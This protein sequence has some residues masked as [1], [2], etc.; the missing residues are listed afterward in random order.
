MDSFNFHFER[1]SN[2]DLHPLSCPVS[3]LS[4]AKSTSSIDQFTHHHGKGDSA[5]SSFSGGSNAPD[6]SSPFIPYCREE[7]NPHSLQYTDMK[8]VK[9]VYHPNELNSNPKSVEK[10]YRSMEAISQQCDQRSSVVGGRCYDQESP[11]PPPPPFMPPPPP[12]APPPPPPPTR[13]DSFITIRNLENSRSYP[14]PEGQV[15]EKTHRRSPADSPDAACPRPDLDYGRRVSQPGLRDPVSRDGADQVPEPQKPASVSRSPPAFLPQESLE[16]QPAGSADPTETQRPRRHSAQEG[17]FSAEKP[18]AWTPTVLNGNIQ[19]KGQFYFVTGVCKPPDPGF[20]GTLGGV[21]EGEEERRSEG[22]RR[23]PVERTHSKV[24]ELLRIIRHRRQGSQDPQGERAAYLRNQALSARN[25]H[26]EIHGG[27]NPRGPSPVSDQG[28]DGFDGLDEQGQ[29]MQGRELGLSSRRH[30]SSSHHIFY[31][32]PEDRLSQ[33]N[34][35]TEEAVLPI[36]SP[37]PVAGGKNADQGKK[38]MRQLFEDVAKEKISKE[39]T[40]LL[41]HLTGESRGVLAHRPKTDSDPNGNSKESRRNSGA[42]RGQSKEGP[43]HREERTSNRA[44]PTEQS[45]ERVEMPADCYNTLDESFK[46]YYKEKLK[47]AQSKVL[48]ETSFKRKDLQ[49]SWPHRI[50]QRPEKRPSVLPPVS[51]LQCSSLASESSAPSGPE[52]PGKEREKENMKESFKESSKEREKDNSM[53]SFKESSKERE[54]DNSMESFRESIKEKENTKESFEE[55]IKELEKENGKESG[56]ESL[57]ESG[58]E[59]TNESG[60]ENE[61]ENGRPPNLAQPQVARI[62]GRRRL[63]P[64]QKKLCYSEP[65]KL[66]QLGDGPTHAAQRS[67]GSERESLLSGEDLSEHGMGTAQRKVLETRGRALSASSLF[68]ASLKQ[69]QHKA[70]VAYMERKTGHRTTE[71]QQPALLTPDQ[72]HSTPGKPSDWGPRPLSGNAGPR[73]KL[74]RPLSAGRILDSSSS[75]VRYSQFVSGHPGAHARQSSW[76]ESAGS[77][78]GKS[79]SAEDLLDQPEPPGFFRARSTSTPHAFQTVGY[80]KEMS[81]EGTLQRSSS[82]KKAEGEVPASKTRAASVSEVQRVRVSAP[83]GKSM[84]ELG[85]SRASRPPVLS[86]S[87]D[88]LDQLRAQRAGPGRENRDAPFP[89]EAQEK[90]QGCSQRRPFPKQDSAPQLSDSEDRALSR[91]PT[92]ATPPVSGSSPRGRAQSASSSG[93]PFTTER[94]GKSVFYPNTPLPPPPPLQ[95]CGS[96]EQES[97]ALPSPPWGP[98]E[99][100]ASSRVKTAPPVRPLLAEASAGDQD[101]SPGPDSSQEVSLSHGVTTDPSSWIVARETGSAPPQPSL[102]PDDVIEEAPSRH[103]LALPEGGSQAAEPSAVEAAEPSRSAE[104][105]QQAEQEGAEPE[106]A[107]PE[108]GP[109]TEDA[110]RWEELVEEVVAKDQSLARVLYPVT[111]RKTAVMLMEQLLSED[112]LLMGEHYRRK[113]ERNYITQQ[114]GDRSET[115]EEEEKVISPVCENSG[116]DV[117]EQETQ[118]TPDKTESDV[119]E[120]KRLLMASIAGRLRAVEAQREALQ[121]EVRANGLQGGAVD[122]LVRRGCLPAEHERYALFVGDL[123]RVVSLLLCLSARLARVQNAL[124][125]VDQDTDA[126]EKESLD[127]R[128]ALLCKQREDAKD[129]KDNLDRR[130]RVVSAILSKHLTPEQLQDYRRFVQTKAA[131]LIRQKDLEERQRLGEEQLEC[132]SNSIPL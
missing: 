89:A 93:V 76:M 72:G 79:A 127:S 119:T 5:Y 11:L 75:S 9:A 105:R 67:L 34:S 22:D 3:R 43:T 77:A 49:L 128:H 108:A 112:T 103:A 125:T 118:H 52:V 21:A 109:E 2:L 82:P 68:K 66:H 28:S 57:K 30:H 12:Q 20:G 100:R 84:E 61:K 124:S 6:Y 73:K 62:G 31:C 123:E 69:I 64:E 120:K 71:P 98:R 47:D 51:S 113:Q 46:K 36:Q 111:N 97:P 87:S 92:P 65:E 23:R 53:E 131:I 50:R 90:P 41:Y 14:Y 58:K 4:P 8:Y 101:G 44:T 32:G 78:P 19:H 102:P 60:K 106:G 13:L 132:L 1:V 86:K 35:S 96:P 33:A 55:S 39:T 74:L 107:E 91:T 94:V 99:S 116:Y 15:A 126:E 16:L 81:P 54:K 29:N 104:P 25:Q 42:L 7:T 88:E 129:L 130:E 38:G 24:E 10:L 70:L 27:V 121:E 110:R 37:D 17:G 26:R 115:K 18:Q 85:V 45:Q 83:R 117:Q 40:P 122:A 56:K 59:C 80:M 48:R 114:A 63:T 95:T